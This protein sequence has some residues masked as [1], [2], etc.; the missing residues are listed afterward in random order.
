MYGT[1][2]PSPYRLVQ[3]WRSVRRVATDAV[4]VDNWQIPQNRISDPASRHPRALSEWRVIRPQRRLDD[5]PTNRP[6]GLRAR[7]PVLIPNSMMASA[8]GDLVRGRYRNVDQHG[9]RI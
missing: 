9:G 4:K 5:M 3:G 6:I 2:P 8:A 7:C 1:H